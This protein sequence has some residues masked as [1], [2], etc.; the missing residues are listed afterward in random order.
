MEGLRVLSP[1]LMAAIIGGLLA[2]IIEDPFVPV[3]SAPAI[4][5]DWELGEKWDHPV[6]DAYTF[7]RERGPWGEFDKQTTA[8]ADNSDEEAAAAAARRAAIWRFVGISREEQGGGVAHF[9]S[10]AGDIALVP[11]GDPAPS[12]GL[13]VAMGRDWVELE[14]GNERIRLQLFQPLGS[15]S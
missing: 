11:L 8:V 9:L 12:G 2:L 15:A 7:L 5:S 3:A 14:R 13:V 4:S 10:G 1:V 6:D